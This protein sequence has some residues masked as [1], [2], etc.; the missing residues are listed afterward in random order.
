MDRVGLDMAKAALLSRNIGMPERFASE[1]NWS[2]FDLIHL[3]NSS[4]F[5]KRRLLANEVLISR[6]C[7]FLSSN[8][9]G[10]LVHHH[11]SMILIQILSSFTSK[12]K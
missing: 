4:M 7:H 10:C 11:M 5:T 3:F 12:V 1:Q 6:H 2:H 9:I 8:V